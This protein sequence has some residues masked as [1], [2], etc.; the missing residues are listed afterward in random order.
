M[1]LK[2]TEFGE[3][4]IVTVFTP[5]LRRSRLFNVTDFCSNRKLIIIRLPVSD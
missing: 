2:A 1:R 3:L 5:L 4:R